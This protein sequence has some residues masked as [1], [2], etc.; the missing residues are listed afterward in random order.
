MGDGDTQDVPCV[1]RPPIGRRD[2]DAD[3]DGVAR[4]RVTETPAA[5]AQ[6]DAMMDAGEVSRPSPQAGGGDY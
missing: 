1:L 2:A 4:A 5:S 6:D 3:D